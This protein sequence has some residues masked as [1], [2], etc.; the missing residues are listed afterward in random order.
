MNSFAPVVIPTLNRHIHFKRCVESLS[1]CTHADKT[2]LFIS[3]DYPLYE[4]HWDGYK[5]IELYLNN[6]KGFHTVNIIKRDE[7]LGAMNNYLKSTSEIFEKYDRIIFTEDDNE[8]SPNFLDYINK[9]LQKFENDPLIYAICGYKYLV[10]IHKEYNFNFFFYRGFSAWGYGT[11]KNK[12]KELVLSSDDLTRFIK[13]KNN[14]K[15]LNKVSKRHYY[16]IINSILKK[17]IRYGDFAVFINN[18]K[19][20]QYCVFPCISKVRNFGHDG[21]GI[22]CGT[23]GSKVFT[24]QIIDD[25]ITFEYSD[26]VPICNDNLLYT[27]RNYFSLSFKGKIRGIIL[28]CIFI[29]KQLFRRNTN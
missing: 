4:K 2:D 6:I 28:H 22:N 16:N 17:E 27:L 8:F 10:P 12:S 23:I 24:N 18:I 13:Q 7:N 11:W 3:L 26:S 14:V 21:S 15:E 20:D 1:R 19:F 29:I 9:G 25:N 5:R